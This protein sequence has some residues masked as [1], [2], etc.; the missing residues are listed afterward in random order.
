MISLNPYR[1]GFRTIKTAIGMALA[2]IVAQ[3]IGLQNFAS[4]AILVVLCIK[5]TKVNSLNA[6]VSRFVSCFIAIFLG[7]IIFNLLGTHALIMGIVVLLFIPITVVFK[8]Q[9]GVVTSCVIL[10][11]LFKADYV[12]FALIINEI[13]LLI[14]GLGIAFSMNLIM[15]SLDK[16]LKKHKQEI[17]LRIA[18]I[19]KAFSASC[20][21]LNQ[22][23]QINYSALNLTISKAKSLAFRDVKNHFVRNENSYYHYFDMR[24]DQLEIIKRIEA[25]I[26]SIKVS[27]E[28]LLDIASLLDEISDNI[29]SNDYTA[30]RLHSLYEIRLRIDDQ[31]LP[32]T[33][34]ALH[35]KASEIQ[36][37]NELEAYLQIKSQ[38]GSLRM[39]NEA[40]SYTHLTLPTN[41]VTCRSRW[42]PYH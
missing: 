41:T 14:V 31:P 13:L 25:L 33:H 8:V 3:A 15:P 19:F 26:Q 34:D 4:S 6:I 28:T 17:E 29:N 11:H 40:V 18:D 10:L 9:E 27:D 7:A 12:D 35:A 20:R 16:P 38:F 39:H 21:D 24:Q 32:E 42:S 36:I 23:L 1:I 30:M 2:M 22:P 37:L 5:D